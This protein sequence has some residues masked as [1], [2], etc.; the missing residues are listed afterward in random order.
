MKFTAT[1]LIKKV[2]GVQA[3]NNGKLKRNFLIEYDDN[4][5]Q[6]EMYFTLYGDDTKV[7]MVDKPHVGATV[8]VHFDISCRE[9]N[10]KYFTNLNAWKVNIG[11]KQHPTYVAPPE[12][13]TDAE[14][15]PF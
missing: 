12:A 13:Q 3:L 7:G 11:N 1:G 6:K 14:D 10:D 5:Y 9:W 4:G 2:E 15:F 8:E